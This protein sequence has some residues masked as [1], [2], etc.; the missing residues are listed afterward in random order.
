MG[1]AARALARSEHDLD[2]VAELHA[3]AFEQIAGGAA[4]DDEVLREVSEAA[5]SVGVAPDSPEAARSHAAR[6]ARA[7]SVFQRRSTV[8][9][10]PPGGGASGLASPTGSRVG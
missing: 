4:V 8:S 2:R 10:A 5:A 1:A 9:D 3:A 6:R 7:G